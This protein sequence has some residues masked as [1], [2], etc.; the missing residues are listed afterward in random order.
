MSVRLTTAPTVAT[1][2]RTAMMREATRIWAR[3][4][5]RLE[6][7]DPMARPAGLSLR[8]LTLEHTG[9]AGIGDTAVLGEL[10][11]GA[12]TGAAA[13]IATD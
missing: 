11:R 12:G 3:A 1:T 4:G 13:M 6:W 5:V 2:A 8:V 9:P 7:L 10:V